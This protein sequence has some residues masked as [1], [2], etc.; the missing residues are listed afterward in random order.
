MEEFILLSAAYDLPL[1]DWFQG[2]GEVR[3][4]YG[5]QI[6]RG[7]LRGVLGKGRP[8]SIVVDF[9]DVPDV[10]RVEQA[11][12][13]KLGVEAPDVQRVALE[14]W[15]RSFAEERDRRIG[16]G[17]AP[18]RLRTLRAGMTKRMTREIEPHLREQSS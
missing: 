10:D 14:L 18:S 6:E 15:G 11:V 2:D 5:V 7:A 3:L 8:W 17:V 4:S 1:S 12:S 16:E 9:T 13:H